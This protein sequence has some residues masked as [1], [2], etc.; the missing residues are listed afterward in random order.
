MIHK[1][2]LGL[3]CIEDI[4]ACLGPEPLPSF[5]LEFLSWSAFKVES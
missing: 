4:G 5:L 1:S 2:V 3:H